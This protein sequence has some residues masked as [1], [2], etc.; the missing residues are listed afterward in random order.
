MRFSKE[1][2]EKVQEASDIVQVISERGIAL[3]RA[4]N[5][6]KALCP[7]HSE[8]TPSFTVNPSQGFFHCFGCGIS[9][10]SIK[11][12]MEYD[13]LSFVDTIIELA[14][15]FS[16]PLETTVSNSSKSH[17]NDEG[18]HCLQISSQYYQNLL[19]HQPA[20]SQIC[21][22]YL[23]K[24]SVP[25]EI[26]QHFHLGY[27]PEGWDN[28]LK[29]LTHQG[30][31]LEIME[32]VGLIKFSQKSGKPYDVF[33]NRLIFPIRDK[34]GRC[35]AFGARALSSDQ[36][37]KYL[38]SPDSQYYHKSKVLYGFYEGL[39]KI[40]KGREIIVV[41][42]YLDVARLHQC[43]YENSVAPCGTA[44]TVEQITTHQKYLDSVILIFDGDKAGKEAGLR[45]SKLLLPIA[46]NA[47][48]VS[49][50][51]GEDPDSFLINKGSRIFSDLLEKKISIFEY[52]VYQTLEKFP[53]D[54]QGKLKGI[55]VLIP[56]ILKIQRDDLR[57]LTQVRLAEIL[58]I[59]LETVIKKTEV[60]QSKGNY[61]NLIHFT[62][63]APGDKFA[64]EF[65]D[66]KYILQALLT[67]KSL[68]KQTRNSLK[69][70]EFR[71]ENFK[72]LYSCLIQLN[73]DEFQEA[74][75]EDL[76]RAF[77]YF[78]NFL[79]RLF[80]ESILPQ[81]VEG[82]LRLCIQRIKERNSE[83]ELGQCLIQ[84]QSDEEKL[85]ISM[86]HRKKNME[87]AGRRIINKF[88]R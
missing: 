74:T 81:E 19:M 87:M 7:F 30:F 80:M 26:W 24:R 11:F 75:V 48:I 32:K 16:I 42:G 59:P 58:K 38:N 1:F 21:R 76:G 27:A 77:P 6:Y 18:F 82:S 4:G 35:M 8:K 22:E 41:E 34:L 70:S 45:S 60:L 40:K 72:N 84:A 50:P 20:I 28:L 47:N 17:I 53:Q 61:D 54:M 86:E 15:R 12:V 25:V 39:N 57:Q 79:M 37:P 9:G 36:Q 62:E 55:E 63:F 83:I 78:S 49:L 5:T 43:G 3:K 52:F 23:K 67:K 29:H 44:L 33:R 88:F 69:P 66:E 2:I 71:N 85:R 14:N 65:S 56:E 64:E 10:N 68:L 46:I 13:K 73:D 31:S 51:E